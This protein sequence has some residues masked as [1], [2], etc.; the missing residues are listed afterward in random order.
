[1]W[2]KSALRLYIYNYIYIYIGYVEGL[3]L[4]KVNDN[5]MFLAQIYS[6]I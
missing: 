3:R 2:S 6:S 1:M 4:K 5:E